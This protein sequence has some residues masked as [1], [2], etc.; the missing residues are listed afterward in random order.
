MLI[1]LDFA[2]HWTL[3]QIGLTEKKGSV[4]ENLR[5]VFLFAIFKNIMCAILILVDVDFLS[6]I[7]TFDS[8]DGAGSLRPFDISFDDVSIPTISSFSSE[9]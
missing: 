5:Y 8:T 4:F 9:S 3:K 7:F 6:Q 1:F 2:T